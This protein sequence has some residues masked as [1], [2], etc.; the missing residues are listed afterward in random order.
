M[1]ATAMLHDTLEDT[2]LPLDNI[3][4]LN[5]DVGCMVVWLTDL[6]WYNL[7]RKKGTKAFRKYRK[8]LQWDRL[9]CAPVE[10]QF[11]KLCDMHHNLM[12]MDRTDNFLARMCD[13]MMCLA[14]TIDQAHLPLAREVK[15]LI[16]EHR[17]WLD[18]QEKSNG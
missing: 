9:R 1:A 18:E 3:M 16:Y 15:A 5:I 11:I 12:D 17:E 13:E 4:D 10:V 14:E 8:Q 6:P 7:N 2:E